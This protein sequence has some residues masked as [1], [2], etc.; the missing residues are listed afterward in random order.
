MESGCPRFWRYQNINFFIVEFF[1]YRVRDFY[2]YTAVLV[3]ILF[4]MEC[5]GKRRPSGH[6][7]TGR[8]RPPRCLVQWKCDSPRSFTTSKRST[9]RG[10]GRNS[11]VA[12]TVPEPFL[13][14]NLWKTAEPR[15]HRGG[16]DPLLRRR[17]RQNEARTRP[18]RW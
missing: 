12:R 2:L 17:S 14:K 13:R 7:G 4:R 5:R 1:F 8:A 11:A 10:L 16:A 6:P 18:R 3:Y 15:V 9:G